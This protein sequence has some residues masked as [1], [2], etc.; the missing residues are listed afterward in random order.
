M[1][2]NRTTSE[3][4]RECAVPNDDDEAS[5]PTEIIRR[6]ILGG[7]NQWRHKEVQKSMWQ[8][9]QYW[10]QQGVSKR[11]TKS[12]SRDLCKSCAKAKIAR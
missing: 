2:P 1:G 12:L 8:A 9:T 5:N 4:F 7:R 6:R 3:I 10:R 11:F